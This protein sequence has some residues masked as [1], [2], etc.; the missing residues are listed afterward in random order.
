MIDMAFLLIV[1]FVLVSR[2]V[3]V[4]R[5]D[6]NLPQPHDPLTAAAGRENRVIVN[7]IPATQN[8]SL[9]YRLG[10][11]EFAPDRQ[12]IGDLTSHL[13]QNYQAN[14]EVNIHIRADRS[15]EYQFV[16]PVLRAASTAARRS[17]LDSASARISLVVLQE[18]R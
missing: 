15:I 1:F 5:A 16:E 17:G 2:I 4:E 7:V 10:T 6:L 18:K 12:G 11:H 3:D 13:I 8:Q 9:H 14:P